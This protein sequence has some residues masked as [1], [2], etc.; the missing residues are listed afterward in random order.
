MWRFCLVAG[1][2]SKLREGAGEGAIRHVSLSQRC[3][4][5]L[6][7]PPPFCFTF[8]RV[9]P[10]KTFLHRDLHHSVRIFR[11]GLLDHGQVFRHIISIFNGNTIVET[12]CELRAVLSPT[13][14]RI[15]QTNILFSEISSPKFVR[16]IITLKNVMYSMKSI[17]SNKCGV[18]R[19]YIVYCWHYV[20]SSP[21][22]DN[23][24][25]ISCRQASLTVRFWEIS[26]CMVK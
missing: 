19:F 22:V 13:I 20:F 12:I 14:S 8:R 21:D 23:F 3:L 18:A 9:S 1:W 26:G 15:D 5:R 2:G 7:S 16:V 25:S 24:I 4:P 17:S 6:P 11:F 10:L